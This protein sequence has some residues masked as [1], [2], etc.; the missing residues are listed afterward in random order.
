MTDLARPSAA[1]SG[2]V[3]PKRVWHLLVLGVAFVLARAKLFWQHDVLVFGWRPADMASVALNYYRH[4]FH[5][6]YPQIFWG[7]SGP[8]YVETEFPIV[9]FTTALLFKFLG[10]H[11]YVDDVVP[12]ASGLGIVWVCY[13]FG[14]FFFDEY[15]GVIAGVIAAVVP[16]LAMMTTTGLYPDPPMVLAGAAGLYAMVRWAKDG[17]WYE[18]AA[19]ACLIS[20]AV[21]LKLTALYLGMPALYLFVARYGARFWREPSFW[22]FGLATLLPPVLWYWHAYRLFVEYHNTFGILFGGYSKFS[23]PALLLS[24]R[25]YARVVFR[26]SFYHLTPLAALGFAYGLVI[27]VRERI[28]FLLAWLG[29]IVVYSLIVAVGIRD[30]HYAYLLPLLPVAAPVAALGLRRAL[31]K[32]WD[33]LGR[34]SARAAAIGAFVLA[35]GADTVL[36]TQLFESRDRGVDAPFW[37]KKRATGLRVKSLT[38]PGS[39]LIVVDTQMDDT[40]P[41][42]SMT[43]PDVFYFS[44]RQGWYL[45]MAWLS[46]RRVEELRQ[47]GAAYLVVSGQSVSD[48]KA[49]DQQML[50]Y[51]ASHFPK[52]MDDDDGIVFELPHSRG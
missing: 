27:V 4:G 6:L 22:A 28:G 50:D 15:V 52:L 11:E 16:T 2:G 29:A 3:K 17:K 46:E 48:F 5:L 31:G 13:C 36:A 39:L 23:S 32:I 12:I 26:V 19:A 18:L 34:P 47:A 25:F 14:S 51:L 33:A 35:F 40:T 9:P 10:V 49:R 30:G 8:G 24:P 37:L 41:E 38:K 21:A 20:L 45:S 43:P 1:I 7:G 44:D 42:R